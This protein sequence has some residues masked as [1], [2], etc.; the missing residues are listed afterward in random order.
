[1][2]Q[3]HMVVVHGTAKVAL[4]SSKGEEVDTCLDQGYSHPAA[5]K[6]TRDSNP[7]AACT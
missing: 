6:D 3:A 5:G 4:G 2:G 7:P 1:M